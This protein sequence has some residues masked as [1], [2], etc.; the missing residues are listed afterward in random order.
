M[1]SKAK[2]RRWNA[3][4]LTRPGIASSRREQFAI[5]EALDAGDR[6]AAQRI[7]LSRLRTEIDGPRTVAVMRNGR[8]VLQA[9]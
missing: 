8:K 5:R 6:V 4:P 7:I 3:H 9:V 1:I 2:R